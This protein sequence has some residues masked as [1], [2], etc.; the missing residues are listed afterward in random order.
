MASRR[1]LVAI[2]S[3]CL[4]VG[5]AQPEGDLP[6]TIPL[7]PLQDVMLFPGVARPLHIFEPRYREM[8]R[9]AMEGDR[10]IGM[11]MLQPGYE[12]EY[13]G[14]PP[15]YSVG[16]AGRLGIVEELSDGRFN[17]VLHGLTKFRVLSEDSSRAYRLAEV[18]AVPDTMS[19]D[20]RDALRRH[21]DRLLEI[22]S[23]GSASSRDDLSDEL[24][25]NGLAQ[26][27]KMEPLERLELLKAPSPLERAKALIELARR[28]GTV[29]SRTLPVTRQDFLDRFR[30]P[31]VSRLP[32]AELP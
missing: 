32:L 21:R 6:A 5:A 4:F 27:M 12:D 15:I 13:Y 30:E 9:D 16:C 14:R 10:I 17:I 1:L 18:E 19:D 28:Q 22:L 2:L 29:A 7:F 20:E 25:V 23:P 3:T 8:L 26:M 11:V 24:L 31:D